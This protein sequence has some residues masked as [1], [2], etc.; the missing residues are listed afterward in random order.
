MPPFFVAA[1]S[2]SSA[3]ALA[4]GVIRRACFG[5][6]TSS[7]SGVRS[8]GRFAGGSAWQSVEVTRGCWLGLGVLSSEAV[9]SE[10]R[11]GERSCQ[12]LLGLQ[13]W[14]FAWQSSALPTR[15]RKR[16]T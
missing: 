11:L 13:R 9:R 3:G 1:S 2:A 4:I 16:E 14:K 12:G 7:P 15:T 10:V 5:G 8:N 6:R